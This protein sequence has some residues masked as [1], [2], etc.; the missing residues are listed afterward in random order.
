MTCKKRTYQNILTLLFYLFLHKLHALRGS[1]IRPKINSKYFFVNYFDSDDV[2]LIITISPKIIA[3]QQWES[4]TDFLS[5]I[6]EI[7]PKYE[8]IL[9]N[10]ERKN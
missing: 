7:F 2:N 10:N 8:G 9:F 3:I 4:L 6:N 1:I 5:R